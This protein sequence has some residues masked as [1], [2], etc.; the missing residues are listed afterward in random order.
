MIPDLMSLP[1]DSGYTFQPMRESLAVAC[2]ELE[3]V[4]FNRLRKAWE[5]PAQRP[6]RADWLSYQSR[7]Y[8]D[9][10]V[11]VLHKGHVIA[12]NMVHQWGSLGWVGPVAVDPDHQG[13][14]LGPAL[15]RWSLDRLRA[16]D[17]LT[18]G[19]ETWAHNL[20]NIGLYI[21]SG[22]NIGP[23][24]CVL[25]KSLTSGRTDFN[26][27]PLF[28][29]TDR[30]AI[31]ARLRALWDQIA[32]GLDYFPL[33][34]TLQTLGMGDGFFWGDEDRPD[35]AAIVRFASY[36]EE[37]PPDFASVEVLT[38]RPGEEHWLDTWLADLEALARSAGKTALRISLSSIHA[39]G[40]R[41]LLFD[42]DYRLIKTRLRMYAALQPVAPDAI[43]YLSY[44]V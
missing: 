21:K 24:V 22:F 16:L 35:A 23:I 20:A 36:A 34:D 12:L 43:N 18:I 3:A 17:C 44:S 14:G 33:I 4:A 37:P 5:Q 15:M 19:L 40:L 27:V 42:L 31:L 28:D 8:P 6:R 13:R 1:P 7:L 11:V 29:I 39:A 9:N 26:A 10:T 32:P 30:R 41:R 25:E 2:G 38:A